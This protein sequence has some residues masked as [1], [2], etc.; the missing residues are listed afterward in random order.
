MTDS[1][2]N[3]AAPRAIDVHGHLGPG[4]DENALFTVPGYD[5]FEAWLAGYALPPGAPGIL[6]APAF[7]AY[8]GGLAD[9]RRL[10]DLLA[11]VVRAQ[12]GHF[13]GFCGTVEPHFGNAGFEEVDR[14]AT[15]PGCVGVVWRPKAHGAFA[16]AT[17]LVNL[18]RRAASHGLVPM[19][20]AS[21]RSANEALWRVWNLAEACP[22][23]R[24]VALGALEG[25]D[26]GEQVLANAGRAPHLLYD[27]TGVAHGNA[28]LRRFVAALGAGRLLFGTGALTPRDAEETAVAHEAIA[29]GGL[30]GDD[31]ERVL[32]RNAAGLFRLPVEASS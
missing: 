17:T 18:V 4:D 24:I 32:W 19:V 8:P 2:T 5:E 14:L 6:T 20:H 31:V 16:D 28:G 15:L 10:N 25:W 7:Y 29:G 21:P 23:V 13:L 3:H 27:T 1:S 22:G 30:S 11:A 12:P 26:Q 9:S